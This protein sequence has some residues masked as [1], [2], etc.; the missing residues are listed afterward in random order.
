M[1]AFRWIE[2]VGGKVVAD[3]QATGSGRLWAAARE[4]A[5]RRRPAFSA[6]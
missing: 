5:D 4:G 3:G 6:D 1:A 2:G